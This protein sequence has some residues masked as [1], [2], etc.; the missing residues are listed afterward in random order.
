MKQAQL[1]IQSLIGP[2]FLVAGEKGLREIS[3]E[4]QDVPMINKNDKSSIAKLLVMASKQIEEYFS[5]TRKI[6]D[7]PLDLQGSEF[8]KR[9]WKELRK[10]PYGKTCSYKDIALAL[11]DPNASR[12]VGTANGR[13]PLCIIIP[14]HRVISSDGSLGG[15]SGGIDKKVKLLHLEEKHNHR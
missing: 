13:N 4:E 2:L 6:F 12:A 5:G 9:V 8:Q 14:C 3:F 15:Y 11:H 7:L 10:I 1:K